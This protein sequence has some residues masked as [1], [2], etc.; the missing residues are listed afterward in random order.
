MLKTLHS[1]KSFVNRLKYDTSDSDL[2]TTGM[3]TSVFRID[4]N[5]QRGGRQRQPFRPRQTK[6]PQNRR[7]SCNHCTWLRDTLGIKEVD[8]RH[9]TSSCTRALPTSVRAVIDSGLTS[10]QNSEQE[11]EE[12]QDQGL[13]H[14]DQ[15][16]TDQA[17]LQ[18]QELSRPSQKGTS[19]LTQRPRTLIPRH[20]VQDLNCYPFQKKK[21]RPSRSGY[22][23][24]QKHNPP[25]SRLPSRASLRTS[26]L[27]RDPKLTT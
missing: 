7:P 4:Q 9:S 17:L 6:P 8:N 5:K 2:D 3:A 12:E 26:W 1:Q 14:Q 16:A 20:P 21:L 27:M 23:S 24:W 10:L 15:Q 13:K 11:S 22:S 18:V 19:L 25:G